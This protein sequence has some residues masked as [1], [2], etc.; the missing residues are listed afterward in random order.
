MSIYPNFN[1]ERSLYNRKKDIFYKGSEV[2]IKGFLNTYRKA[3]SI[4][5][6]VTVDKIEDI[7]NY[8]MSNLYNDEFWN[9]KKCEQ[10]LVSEEE[11]RKFEEKL[12]QLRS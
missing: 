10:N 2:L 4:L 1:V 11:Q 9:G 8:W 5:S 6:Y 7:N 12:K 3:N